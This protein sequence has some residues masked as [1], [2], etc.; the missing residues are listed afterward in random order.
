MI[1][2]QIDLTLAIIGTWMILG[3]PLNIALNIKYI[4]KMNRGECVSPYEFGT[5]KWAFLS[6]LSG[7]LP[8]LSWVFLRI[9]LWLPTNTQEKI[10]KKMFV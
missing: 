9:L 5:L 6:L 4:R 2:S 3:L 1:T 7:P 10:W 8:F